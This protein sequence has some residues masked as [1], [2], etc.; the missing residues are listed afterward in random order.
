MDPK[1]S[2]TTRDLYLAGYCRVCGATINVVRQIG[3]TKS[4]FVIEAESDLGGVPLAKV[5]EEYYQ[6]KATCDPKAL[7]H[8]ITDLR[9]LTYSSAVTAPEENH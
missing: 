8:A 4:D 1:S 2:H 9:N 3:A 7:K 6:G 5:I